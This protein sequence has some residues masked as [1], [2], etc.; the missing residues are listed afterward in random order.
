WVGIAP[1]TETKHIF[2][3]LG[4]GTF[5]HSG[6]LAIR[7]AVASG[8]NVTYK[9]LYNSAVA[10]TG[11]QDAAG[12]IPVPE[13]T[14]QLEAE[15]VRRI[16][17]MTDEPGKYPKGVRWARGVEV[18]HRDRLDEA[19][20]LLRDIPG[21]TA[22][23][24]DQRCAAEKRRLRKRGR[25]PDPATRVYINEAV[26][27]GC[28][29]C[30][31]KS[32]CLSVHPVETEFGRKT[33]VHQ[34]S[35]N[36][37]YSCLQGDCPAFLT[38]VPRGAPSRRERRLYT[39]DRELPEPV[40]RVPRDAGV[41]MAGIGGTGVVTVNQILG[42]AAL[43]DGREVRGLDQTGLSQKG[44]PVVSHLKLFDRAPEVSNKLAAGEADCYL[45][46][47]VLVA[48]APQNLEHARPDRTIAVIST[49]RVPT[50]AMV[51]HTDV[52]F[53]EPNALCTAIDRVTRK[54]ENVYVDALGLAETLF[55]DHMA[56]NMIVLGAAYQAGAIPVSAAAIEEA[57]ALNGVAVPMNSQAFRVG[58]LLVADPAWL[59]TIARRRVGAVEVRPVLTPEARALV[60]GVGATGELR[61][62][63]EIRVPE[64]I[65]YQSEAYARAYADFV[66]RVS[67]AERAAVPGASRLGEAV[68]RHL[69]KLMA[70]KDEYEVARLHLNLN[71][72][73][74]LAEEFPD[75]VKINY[76]LQPAF[77]R[78]FG[79]RHKVQVG[80]WLDGFFRLLVA[81]RRVR[82]S[83]FD[84]FGY[85]R[86]RRTE[87][88]LIR[89]YQSLIAKVIP[90]LAPDNIER[91]VKLARLPDLIRGYQT[92][93]L[94]SVERFRNEVRELGF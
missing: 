61:R 24:Y 3:N 78:M 19:Q 46:F 87:R 21:V 62:L 30:G 59:A 36:K 23:V 8:V 45:G 41:F 60:E 33:Q 11:G 92:V 73:P 31:A 13:L 86:V 85:T 67:E 91:A 14:R 5:F 49:S 18:W 37:D 65:E 17:V 69:Y 27:E 16:I 83:V 53:P 38:V 40:L 55:G 48:T 1:F 35:C 28:G 29:D 2:Q 88:A 82:G 57:I 25:L 79:V 20:R 68:A 54:D 6:S 63:L 42:T 84:P 58:R 51:T 7:Q 10:M 71:L 47:D 22:L 9:I 26:C 74:A 32:N 12:A 39:V 44:G 77:L 89:E 80:K 34:S 93:K 90:D 72:A 81:A 15:G 56:A 70:Y 50:G 94:R 75:G 76:Y 52:E 64:L 66:R 43:L 4:D